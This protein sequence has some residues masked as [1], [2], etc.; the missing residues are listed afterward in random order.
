MDGGGHKQSFKHN[1]ANTTLGQ[2]SF[3]YK[4]IP[5]HLT[6]AA[7]ES[8]SIAAFK[9]QLSYYTRRHTN[10]YRMFFADFSTDLEEKKS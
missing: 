6:P 9:S 7:I 5:N 8:R 1:R 3:F 4:I 10:L 2:N